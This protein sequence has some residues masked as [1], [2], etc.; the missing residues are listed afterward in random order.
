LLLCAFAGN[1]LAA[2]RENLCGFAPLRLC[3]KYPCASSPPREI[4]YFYRMKFIGIIIT[5][6]LILS[7]KSK[8]KDQKNFVSV[9]SLIRQQVAHV[10]TSL[11]PIIKLE[12][13][14]TTRID[15]TYIPREKFAE[16]AKDFLE[17]PDLSDKKVAAQYREE[18]A[19]HDQVLNRVILSYVPIDPSKQE[20]KRQELLAT[21]VPG[22]DAKINNII[23]LREINNRDSFLQ[24]KMLWQMDKSFQVVTTRQKPGQPEVVTTTKVIWNEDPY[25]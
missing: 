11:Y 21:P 12:Y 6:L 17:T 22:Q 23:I 25:Q 5:C 19:I 20:F 10:D 9:V 15:T 2:L 16:V 8:K 13:T 3:G 14:D 4:N 7:C 1:I 18:P 24:K